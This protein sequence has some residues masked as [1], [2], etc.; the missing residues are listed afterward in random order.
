VLLKIMPS[1]KPT[2]LFVVDEE[3]FEEIEDF[4][5]N[6]RIQS[7]SEAVRLLVKEGLKNL[8]EKPH[9]KSKS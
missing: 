9:K 6:N 2:I 3:T 1:E 4:R 8:K 5:F 7:R